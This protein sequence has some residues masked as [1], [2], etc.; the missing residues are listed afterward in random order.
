RR[1]P[2]LA[3]AAVVVASE[4]AERQRPRAG[5]GVKERLL[6]D[7]VDLQGG[8]VA[9]RNAQHAAVVVANLADALESVEDLAAMPARVAADGVSVQCFYQLWSGLRRAMGQKLSERDLPFGELGHTG[10]NS[11]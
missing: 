11:Y 10:S 4:H 2:V 8:D 5:I 3:I 9:A 1:H 6:L 7:R